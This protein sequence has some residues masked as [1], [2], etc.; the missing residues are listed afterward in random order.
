MEIELQ[1]RQ[2]QTEQKVVVVGFSMP[3][4]EMVHFIIKWTLAAI[5]AMLFLAAAGF[6]LTLFLGA[7]VKK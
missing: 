4:G 5:P 3:F 6:A 1:Q 7:L 2:T